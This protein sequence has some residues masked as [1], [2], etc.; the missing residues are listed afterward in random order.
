MPPSSS[1]MQTKVMRVLPSV[2]TVWPEET[3]LMPRNEDGERLY[4]EASLKLNKGNNALEN[5]LL[6]VPSTVLFDSFV[7][8]L[9]PLFC[10]R[11]G[12]WLPFEELMH[13]MTVS[14]VKRPFPP[15]KCR[16]GCGE[17]FEG[18]LHRMLQ[19]Q[20]YFLVAPVWA[21]GGLVD[22]ICGSI[23]TLSPLV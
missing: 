17:T 12:Q 10:H 4:N 2:F 22:R 23:I 5:N 8:P 18:G 15:I 1:A 7:Y 3:S 21:T 6:V 16:L 20:I 14:C 13:H 9:P 11:C 19:V